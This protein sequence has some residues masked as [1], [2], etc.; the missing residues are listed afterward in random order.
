MNK[1]NIKPKVRQ[2]LTKREKIMMVVNTFN[3]Y[4][5]TPQDMVDEYNRLKIQ[6]DSKPKTKRS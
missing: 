1:K 4:Q 3:K 6:N 2:E 5:V